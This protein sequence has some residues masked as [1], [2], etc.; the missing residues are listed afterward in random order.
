MVLGALALSASV[1]SAM[2]SS[3]YVSKKYE[4]SESSYK[5]WTLAMA[6]TEL[7]TTS[8]ASAFCYVAFPLV[9]S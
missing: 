6:A 3:Y 2:V 8:L 5:K 4:L 9:L 1:I 7:L